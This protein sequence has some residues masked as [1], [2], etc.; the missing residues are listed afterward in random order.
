MSQQTQALQLVEQF[1][2]RPPGIK[3]WTWV[4]R[5]PLYYGM[6]DRVQYP[7]H[8]FQ[9]YEYGSCGSNAVLSELIMSDPVAYVQ[10]TTEL[11]WNGWG[12]IRHGAY[13][14]SRLAAS[15]ELRNYRFAPDVN[16]ADWI[17]S[18]TLRDSLNRHTGTFNVRNIEGASFAVEA[19]MLKEIG[20][21]EV[22]SR[23]DFGRS[24][25]PEMLGEAN[26]YLNR[27][28]RVLIAF[29]STL[30]RRGAQDTRPTGQYNHW[31]DLVTGIYTRQGSREETVEFGV[32]TWGTGFN[33]PLDRAKPLR[34]SM[35]QSKYF[36]YVAARY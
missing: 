22:H 27:K 7:S 34:R 4:E 33:V 15:P 36:G 2:Q 6:R 32:Y 25:S 30:I 21:Q 31:A 28:Y 23:G 20:Y 11:Y 35:F 3:M 18:A 26:Y 14:G 12:Y 16:P 19:L 24:A 9:G 13:S 1:R 17:I 29:D 8:V 5:A 10:L